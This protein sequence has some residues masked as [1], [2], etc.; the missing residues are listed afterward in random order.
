MRIIFMGSPNYAIY[1]LEA[2]LNSRHQVIAVATQP[3]APSGRGHKM[4]PCAVKTYAQNRGIKVLDYAKISRDGIEEIKNLQPDI[5][6]TVAFG[7][8][9]SGELIS[10]PKYGVIN[11][12]ASLLPKHRGA[13]PI[14][15]A[16]LEGDEETGVT[17][18]QTE[19]GLDSGA[20]LLVKRTNILEDE[21]AGDLAN[22]L[23]K[24][25]AEAILSTLEL[26]EKNKLMPKV[27]DS[28]QASVCTKI[29]KADAIINWNR[30]AKQIK[31]QILSQNPSPISRSVINGEVL[32]IYR[33]KLAVG[34]NDTEQPAGTIIEPTSSKKGVFVQ[35]GNG[36][37][38]LTEVCL[39]NGKVMPAKN[40]VMSK[41]ISVGMRFEAFA[42]EARTEDPNA[43]N[44]I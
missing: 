9:L 13:S 1:S 31:N 5:I 10:I 12:H 33:A 43:Q 37:L 7:Q 32:K 28:S 41:K 8:I 38:E 39:P 36:I 4:V 18:V 6:I 22:R 25:S 34:M 20:I 21:T 17:I 27:Q 14:Q 11:A 3:D 40:L 24:M 23:S 29:T 19:I 35:C 30:R 44:H 15:T 2:L 26:I 16:I 42:F